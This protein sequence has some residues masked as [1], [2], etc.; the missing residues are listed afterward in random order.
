[1]KIAVNARFLAKPFTGIGQYTYFLFKHL[2]QIA[3][4][5]E[6]FLLTPE[7]VDLSFPN[8]VHQIRVS[9]K[10]LPSTSLTQAYWERV[11]VPREMKNLKVDLAHFPYPS[12]PNKW[13][14]FPTVV[15]LHDVIPWKM[16]A[17]RRRWRSKLIHHYNK[18]ALKKAD[19]IITV[20]DFSKREIS[21][22]LKI[23]PKNISSILLAPPF[24]DK[25][26]YSSDLSL[27]RDYFIY[28]GGYDERKNIVR[29][30]EAYQKHIAPYYDIDLVMVGGANRGLEPFKANR[31]LEKVGK[32]HR[33]KTKGKIV[34]TDMLDSLDL[35]SLY[36]QAKALVNVSLYEGFNLPLLE[37]MHMKIP[38]ICSDLEVHHEVT[39]DQALFVDSK[40]IDS[41]GLGMHKILHDKKLTA[42]L[43][44]KG[45]QRA[46]EF[47]WQKTAQETLQV[48][49]LFEK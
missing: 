44:E 37:A 22:L 12:N 38:V 20:S 49:E 9:E 24:K 2:A 8:N 41:I 5:R 7:L 48:Y 32:R 23:S 40:N 43:V 34:F 31:Y 4:E 16:K 21:K 19:H 39:A 46:Q 45:F 33:L 35:M 14:P 11:L 25:E 42:S 47:S 26:T 13:L 27:R 3:P 30:M 36:Q 18:Q 10:K 17:Y 15:T 1:M 28:V 29:L 6:I